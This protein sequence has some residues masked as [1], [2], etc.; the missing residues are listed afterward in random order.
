MMHICC[1]RFALLE[2]THVVEFHAGTAK[3]KRIFP[4][5]INHKRKER[6]PPQTTRHCLY[7]ESSDKNELH[8]AVDV[9]ILTSLQKGRTRGA[10]TGDRHQQCRGRHLA[11]GL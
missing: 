5:A 11:Y 7:C 8:L 1:G 4:I 3:P 2:A 6:A 9:P 10:K